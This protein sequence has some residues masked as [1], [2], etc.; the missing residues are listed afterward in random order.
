M[1]F[2]L[3]SRNGQQK[4]AKDRSQ[5]QPMVKNY[6]QFTKTVVDEDESSDRT[7]SVSPAPKN[8]SPHQI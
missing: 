8:E 1:S 6:S 5:S 7:V 2:G 4:D 3:G